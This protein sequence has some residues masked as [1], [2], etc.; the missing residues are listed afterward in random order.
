M[1]GN[2][3]SLASPTRVNVS[4][5]E[6]MHGEAKR[7]ICVS[8]VLHSL[9]REDWSMSRTTKVSFRAMAPE[10]LFDYLGVRVNGPKAAGKKIVLNVDFTDL[11]KQYALTV[12]NG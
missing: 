12:E 5:G 4:D 2:L 7:A 8:S 9:Q 3:V 6:V 10:M 11:K 1:V